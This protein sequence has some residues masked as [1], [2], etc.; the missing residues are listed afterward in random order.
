MRPKK[1]VT[2]VSVI[3]LLNTSSLFASDVFKGREIYMREC[4]ACHGNSG[5]G[6]MPGLPNFTESQT[7]FK[8]DNVLID[9]IKDG[10]GIM[11]GF[12]GLLTDEDIRDVTAYLRSFL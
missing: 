11:P 7:L 4:M 12:G 3:L 9:I 1:I 2:L 10:R 8:T 5:E 6:N